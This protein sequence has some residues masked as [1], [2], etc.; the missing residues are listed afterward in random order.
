MTILDQWA[1][2]CLSLLCVPL[3]LH[4]S[5]KMTGLTDVNA[6]VASL[7][8]ALVCFGGWGAAVHTRLALRRQFN[9]EIED[10]ENMR[11]VKEDEKRR[12]IDN[13]RVS[14]KVKHTKYLS[15]LP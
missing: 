15:P 1:N 4:I 14:V 12:Y 7:L 2:L 5:A 8:L 10:G 11:R 6:A 13:L 3:L 9:K